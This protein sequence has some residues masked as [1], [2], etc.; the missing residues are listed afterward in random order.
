MATVVGS[1]DYRYELVESWPKMPKYWG[2]GAASDAAVNSLDEVYVF[3]RGDHPLTIWDTEGNFVSSWGERTFSDNEHGIFIAP[4]D[5]VWLVDANFHVATKYTPDGTP[6]LTLGRKHRPSATFNGKPFN[7]PTGLAIAPGGELWV[8][9]GYGSHRVHKFSPEGEL[10]LSFGVQGDGPSQFALL[11]NIGV[12][13]NGRVY[14]CD[15][16][17]NRIQIFD[18]QGGYLEQWTD[19]AMPGDLWF[20]GDVVYVVEQGVEGGVSIWNLEG[21]LITRWRG[22]DTD[23]GRTVQSGHGICVDSQGSIYVTELPPRECVTKFQRL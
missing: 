15:R 4:N 16:E 8:S 23:E 1:G 19:V 14:V 7:M 20:V 11:H 6:L 10:I 21:E 13:K 12:D 22:S 2:F 5:E 3:S 9:D 17:N 18:D